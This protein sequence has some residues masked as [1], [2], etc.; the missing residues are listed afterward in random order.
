MDLSNCAVIGVDGGA[1]EAK[2]HHVLCDRPVSPRSFALGKAHGAQIYPQPAD[3]VPVAVT[4]QLSERDAPHPTDAEQALGAAWVESAAHAIAETAV[5]AGQH[6]LLV[7]I[8]MP[9]LKTGD[10]RGIAVIN[11]GPRIPDYL[12][13]LTELL[14]ARGLELVA[15]IDRL[16]SDADY[17]GIGE[18]WAADGAFRDVQNA[19]YVGCGT[20]EADALK[21]GGALVTF[22]AARDWIQKA[23]QMTCGLDT[24]FEQVVSAKGMNA[25]YRARVSGVN[26]DQFPE[27]DALAGKPEAVEWLRAVAHTLAELI[28]ER[29]D[30]VKNGRRAERPLSATYLTLSETHPHRGTVLQRVVVGQRLGLM[31]GDARYRAVFAAPLE[32]HLANC[33]AALEDAELSGQILDGDALKSGWLHASTLRAAPA[34][35]AGV[36]AV[37]ALEA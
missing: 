22:D 11:N 15:P 36:A 16:G 14:T 4:E 25:G 34:L 30:T 33:I 8:G 24:T 3:F 23:W 26:E 6:R 32:T 9:G 10:G 31:L 19:Y 28:A 27:T 18:Q 37:Q 29:V 13:R 17:C 1:T 7:G 20:G 2:A 35:G 12:D 5:G 21:L